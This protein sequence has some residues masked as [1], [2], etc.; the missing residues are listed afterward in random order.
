MSMIVVIGS[1]V[2]TVMRKVTM[3]NVAIVIMG[4]FWILQQ[5]DWKNVPDAGEQEY[6]LEYVHGAEEQKGSQI[7][8][9]IKNK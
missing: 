6:F 7:N 4:M 5:V 9:D 8:Q 2:T 3:E 1:L